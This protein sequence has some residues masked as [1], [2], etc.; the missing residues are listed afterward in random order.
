MNLSIDERSTAGLSLQP[1][2]QVI[3]C[4]K[5]QHKR[6]A[7]DQGP[8]WQCPN[9]GVAYNKAMA[10]AEAVAHKVDR[11]PSARG[12]QEIDRDEWETFTPGVISLSLQGR[13][14]R[15]RYLAFSWPI[16]LLSGLGMAA[17]VAGPLHKQSPNIVLIIFV[18]VMWCWLSLRSMALRL[19][20]VDRSAKWLLAL[21][22]LPGV[23]AALGSG[24]QIVAI[25]GGIFWVLALLLVLLPGTEGDNDYGPPPGANTGLVKVGAVLFLALMAL[26]V[27][28]NIKYLQYI[29]SG[30]LNS[31]LPTA[32]SLGQG[33]PGSGTARLAKAD[34]VGTWQGR[35][36]S[37]RV[38]NF[39]NSLFLHL[40]GNSSVRA[41]GPLRVL[42]GNHISVGM[43]PNPFFLNVTVPP[44][45]EGDGTRMTL[46]GVELTRNN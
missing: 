31:A 30:K 26:A 37:L 5:C 12:R 6:T 22:L 43:G 19:H 24:Q 20:D 29:R 17:A 7:D 32:P 33:Q 15:L 8:A 27:V 11:T 36:M 2:V 38:D 1:Q 16:M 13:I 23:C 9:C 41:D 35:N 40:D 4:P 18:S 34:F 42:D 14:G 44:H 39:G 45:V 21:L 25:C 28:G 10:S 3:A 46:D